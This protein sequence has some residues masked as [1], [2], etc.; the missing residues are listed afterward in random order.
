MDD[1]I[2]VAQVVS[3][4]FDAAAQF[5]EQAA[6]AGLQDAR[7][8]YLLAQAY[9]RQGK[10][11]EAR[12][13]LRRI[14]PPDANIWL[15]LGILSLQEQNVAQAEQELGKAFDLDPTSYEI[16]HNLLLARLTLDQLDRCEQL[17]P[18]AMNLAPSG[19]ERRFLAILQRL[20]HHCRHPQAD[21]Y[22]LDPALME[23]TDED[24]QRLLQLARSLG[25]LDTAQKL[26]RTLACARANSVA[27]QTAY[28]ETALVQGKLLLDQARWNE[29]EQLLTPLTQEKQVP[30][31]T[32]AALL[33][34]L[35]CC[36]C[37]NQ[38]FD[39]GIRHFTAALKLA[40]NDPRLHQNMALAYEWQGE[41]QQADPHWNRYFELL[42]ARWPEP[43]DQDNYVEQL[44]FESLSRLSSRYAE[45]E[46]WQ[47][48][49]NYM[50]RAQKLRPRD[51][52][53]LER[54]F[55]LFASGKRPDDARR[56]LRQLREL[57]PGE[58]Q[59]EL[60][61]VDLIEA[62]SLPDI[63]RMLTEIDR[64]MQRYPGD[65]RVE[66]KAVRMVGNVVPLMTNLCDQL[67]E[68]MSKIID[69]VRHLPNYQINWGAVHDAM[70]DLVREFRKLR[71]IT[72]KCLPLVSNDE[73]RR[74]IRDLTEHIDKKIEVCKS[75]GG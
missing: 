33:N 22:V 20:L 50:Q 34:L 65:V 18:Q 71:R 62:K 60:Y 58:P 43:P 30:R 23:I 64:I 53:V 17:L 69:Q 42:D 13:A 74:I 11:A 9:K 15:Q 21:E 54:L 49:V 26:L 51:P 8:S 52:D 61:E 45:K 16:C 57:R 5:L 75:M 2:P 31:T 38:D 29:A 6:K 55:H 73:H 7:V 44:T 36:S 72:N 14:T 47:N 12:Q 70:R 68:Q 40:A 46:K 37:L 4:R 48:A 3:S 35:G 28:L 24:E 32:Q 63:E 67:T 66:E 10:P 25:Q 1:A 59:Y 41:L 56:T 39:Q 19:K 27:V